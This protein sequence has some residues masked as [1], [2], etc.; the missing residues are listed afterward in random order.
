MITLLT[1]LAANTGCATPTTTG[2]GDFEPVRTENS[3]QFPQGSTITIPQG[4]YGHLDQGHLRVTIPNED[5]AIHVFELE[6]DL[7]S[8]MS[9]SL[10]NAFP[11]EVRNPTQVLDSPE[12]GWDEAKIKIFGLDNEE[13]ILQLIGKR[14]DKISIVM[15]LRAKQS[16]ME[17]RGAQIMTLLTSIKAPGKDSN[18]LSLETPTSIQGKESQL[19]IFVRNAMDK[20][21]VPGLAI[22][23]IEDGKVAYSKAFGITNINTQEPVDLDT[24]FMIGSTSKSLTTLLISKLA[25]D[26]VLKWKDKVIDLY[27]GFKLKDAKLSGELLL[28]DL[29][30]ACTGIPRHDFPMIL[31]H[32]GKNA[33]NL[34]SELKF[35]EQTTKIRETFQYNNQLVAA[36]GFIAAKKA[37]PDLDENQAYAELMSEYIF[38]PLKMNRTT[39]NFGKATSESNYAQCYAKNLQGRLDPIDLQYERFAEYVGPS[40]GVWSTINDMAQYALLELNR[41]MTPDGQVVVSEEQLMHRRM[42][43][44]RIDQNNFYG[45]GWMVGKNMGLDVVQHG[46]ATLAFRSEF[47]LFPGTKRAIIILSNSGSGSLIYPPIFN[48]VLEIWYNRDLKSNALLTSYVDWMAKWEEQFKSK[49]FDLDEP[50]VRPYLGDHFNSEIGTISIK[51]D[52]SGYSVFLGKGKFSLRGLTEDSGAKKLVIVDLP[53]TSITIDPVFSE[54]ISIKMARGQEVYHFRK[55]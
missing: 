31:N 27:P 39:V 25:D 28:E 41:G 34:L 44:V 22:A 4:M 47:V 3:L 37:R 52:G 1:V 6:M 38:S 10:K 18:D 12:V 8:A 36:S 46:G 51:R 40:G 26:G 43:Q 19:E 32:A 24:R 29:A 30:C 17:K 16:L 48:K 5:I 55:M 45:L 15:L 49:I 14:K 54:D 50:F 20:A 42:Q 11:D 23:L 21:Q 35:L 13:Q 53:F 33:G 9:G 2:K 7:E